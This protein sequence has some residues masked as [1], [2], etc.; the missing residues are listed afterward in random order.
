MA[1]F[2]IDVSM[3]QITKLLDEGIIPEIKNSIIMQKKL[4]EKNSD[5]AIDILN[6]E[7]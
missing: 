5:I 6:G 4:S 7:I 3:K 1:K 2:D